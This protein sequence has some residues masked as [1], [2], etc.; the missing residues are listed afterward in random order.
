MLTSDGASVLAVVQE[1]RQQLFLHLRGIEA[2]N[3]PAVRNALIEQ[4]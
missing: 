4:W 2:E 3:D 1:L